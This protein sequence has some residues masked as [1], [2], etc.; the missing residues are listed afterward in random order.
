MLEG[1]SREQNL[2]VR[3]KFV[4]R[5]LHHGRIFKYEESPDK[6]ARISIATESP[7]IPIFKPTANDYIYSIKHQT[8]L[9]SKGEQKKEITHA[10]GM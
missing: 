1:K 4:P 8:S 6:L 3:M 2:R 5:K 10:A 9:P 7:E